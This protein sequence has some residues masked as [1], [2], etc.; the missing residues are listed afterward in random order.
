[1]ELYT[2]ACYVF[3]AFSSGVNVQ[4]GAQV[5]TVRK[6]FNSLWCAPYC[7]LLRDMGTLEGH[8]NIEVEENVPS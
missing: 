8:S 5:S 4:A 2:K 3:S 1:M 6:L 7:F